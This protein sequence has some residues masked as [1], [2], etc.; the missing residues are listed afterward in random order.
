MLK[1]QVEVD[2]DVH[3][4]FGFRSPFEGIVRAKWPQLYSA[5]DG[6]TADEDISI[7]R[8]G[9]YDFEKAEST[10]RSGL[11]VEIAPYRHAWT[12]VY[13]FPLRWQFFAEASQYFDPT[14]EQ[15][16]GRSLDKSYWIPEAFLTREY[17][18]V[19]DEDVEGIPCVIVE[20]PGVDRLWVA[21]QHGYVVCR[22]DLY[23]GPDQ[24]LRERTMNIDLEQV[25]PKIWIP[26]KQVQ[27]TYATL[28][29]DPTEWNTLQLKL[30]LTVTDF[31]I[32]DIGDDAL[33]VQTPPNAFISDAIRDVH[34]QYE[35]V[36]D[37]PKNWVRSWLIWGN[38]LVII[39]VGALMWY[40]RSRKRFGT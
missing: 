34:G 20:C 40:L 31:E 37:R 13:L 8:E 26:M 21:T 7:E 22:R 14:Q 1:Y 25:A 38:V 16:L 29:S 33:A 18:V 10:A 27:E 4:D 15:T 30:T 24:P 23:F 12:A 17:E 3:K 11:N 19:G 6:T 9:A 39:L 35:L 36:G 2:L 28:D 5:I 32:G